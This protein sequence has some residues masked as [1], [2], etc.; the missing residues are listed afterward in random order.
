MILYWLFFLTFVIWLVPYISWWKYVWE[1]FMIINIRDCFLNALLG[2]Y[3]IVINF[4]RSWMITICQAKN[5]KTRKYNIEKYIAPFSWFIVMNIPNC[6]V[7]NIIGRNTDELCRQYSGLKNFL[8]TQ[9]P[10]YPHEISSHC[11]LVSTK[12]TNVSIVKLFRFLF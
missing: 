1:D 2:H 12:K 5:S 6:F 7:K 9:F 11:I 3:Q 8:Y 4:F 10:V